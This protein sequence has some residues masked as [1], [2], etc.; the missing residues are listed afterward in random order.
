MNSRTIF[1]FLFIVVG[2]QQLQAQNFKDKF[3]RTSGIHFADVLL[4][5]L[6]ERKGATQELEQFVGGSI[7]L[8]P[9]YGLR[10]NILEKGDAKS[11]SV[12]IDP[13][14]GIASGGFFYTSE[15]SGLF[16]FSLPIELGFNFGAGSTYNAK[17]DNGFSIKGGINLNLVPLIALSSE[18]DDIKK[19]YPLPHITFSYMSFLGGNDL[20]EFFARYNFTKSKKSLGV[21]SGQYYPPIV[22][23]FGFSK[24]IGY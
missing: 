17:G 21:R 18:G 22:F 10:Y 19:F 16:S 5:P 20:L 14:L 2:V 8:T 6:Y 13:S 11:I 12:G 3:F 15:V 7:L 24:V 23:T 9:H 4:M 1:L